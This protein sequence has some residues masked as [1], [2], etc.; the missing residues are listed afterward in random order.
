MTSW[1]SENLRSSR[2]KRFGLIPGFARFL[3][4]A[5]EYPNWFERGAVDWSVNTA[6]SD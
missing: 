5:V 3:N 4:V 1:Y 6:V 2:I